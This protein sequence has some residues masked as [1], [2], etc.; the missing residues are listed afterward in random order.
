MRHPTEGVLRRLVD[1]PAGVADADRAHVAGCPPCLA[2][3]AA[4]RAGRRARGRCAAAPSRDRRR[5]RRLAA[6]AAAAPPPDR[7]ARPRRRGPAGWRAACAAR[8]VAALGVVVVLAGAGAA[9]AN[10]WLPIFRTER[11]APVRSAPP[12]SSRCPTCPRTATSSVDRH[13]RRPRRCPTPRPPRRATGLAV[14]EVGD[15][16]RGVTGDPPTRW[17]AR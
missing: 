3:L 9:A 16:P 13:A 11:I 4:A 1:E 17:A 14:P 12:T 7:R 5:R 15:L 6:A 10:D 2:G 8:V